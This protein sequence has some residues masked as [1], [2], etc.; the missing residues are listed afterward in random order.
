MQINSTVRPANTSMP[1]VRHAGENLI[2]TPYIISL[3]QDPQNATPKQIRMQHF[4]QKLEELLR[5]QKMEKQA[6]H[7]QLLPNAGFITLECTNEVKQ[8]IAGQPEVQRVVREGP[9]KL[10]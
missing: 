8:I 3:R 10:T 9:M 2:Y 7:I 4:Q 1:K 6:R 5:D